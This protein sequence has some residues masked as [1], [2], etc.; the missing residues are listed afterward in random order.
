M[1]RPSIIFRAFLK[2]G[3]ARHLSSVVRPTFSNS[4]AFSRLTSQQPQSILASVASINNSI[5]GHNIPEISPVRTQFEIIEPENALDTDQD[6][7]IYMDS[8]LRKRRLKMKKHK[9]RKRRR[10]QRSLKKRLGKL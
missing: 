2:M 8:V 10:E 6:N 9:L 5:I 1:F 4:F 7:T 3:S